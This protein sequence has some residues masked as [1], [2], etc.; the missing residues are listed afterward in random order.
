M[1]FGKAQCKREDMPD[2]TVRAFTCGRAKLVSCGE[3]YIY[4]KLLVSVYSP[5]SYVLVSKL[6]SLAEER[7]RRKSSFYLL[8]RL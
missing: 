3:I 4:S 8:F 2:V 1:R 5:K 6:V 7:Q